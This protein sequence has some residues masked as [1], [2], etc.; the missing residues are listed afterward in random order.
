MDT[1]IRQS[2]PKCKSLNWVNNGDTSDLTEMDVTGIRCWNCGKCWEIDYDDYIIEKDPYDDSD[3]CYED[4]RNFIDAKE[5]QQQFTEDEL[6]AIKSLIHIMARGVGEDII[7]VLMYYGG[8]HYTGQGK[9][10]VDLAQKLEPKNDELYVDVRIFL[11]GMGI[12]KDERYKYYDRLNFIYKNDK[13]YV[14]NDKPMRENI[15]I[16]AGYE[17]AYS[18]F[19]RKPEYKRHM[20]FAYPLDI[21]LDKIVE[22]IKNMDNKSD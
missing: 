10:L 13:F 5:N 22:Y 17:E 18:L 11:D 15:P 8:F 6:S 3:I 19:Q 21:A 1:F 4:G 9:P 2:C 12:P 7:G 14:R 20:V 16:F